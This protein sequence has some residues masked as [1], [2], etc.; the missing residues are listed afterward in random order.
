MYLLLCIH[1]YQGIYNHVYNPV[2][3]RTFLNTQTEFNKTV[4]A[5]RAIQK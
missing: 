3:K 2:E 5:S 1:E 4:W